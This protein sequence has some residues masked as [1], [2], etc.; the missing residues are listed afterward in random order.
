ME[1]QQN[2]VQEE[3]VKKDTKYENT[4]SP[5]EKKDLMN[6]HNSFWE[7]NQ[8]IKEMVKKNRGGNDLGNVSM[9]QD[10][11]EAF[12]FPAHFGND[13]MADYFDEF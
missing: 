3:S 13:Y 2:Q 6:I 1:K 8:R 4:L 11:I 5:E 10:D 7:E 9:G 12:I